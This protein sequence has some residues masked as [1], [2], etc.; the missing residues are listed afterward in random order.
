VNAGPDR[1]KAL[2][3]ALANARADG[4][5][6]YV[7]LSNGVYWIDWEPPTS[8]WAGSSGYIVVR[9]EGTYEEKTVQ[10]G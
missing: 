5:P 6:R 10:G 4:R 2:E 7:T 9:P 1:T 8:T 3:H